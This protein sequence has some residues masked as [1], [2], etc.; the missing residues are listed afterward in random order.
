ML[1]SICN[2]N[3]ATIH[4]KEIVNG[5]V[6]HICAD[7]A[8][9]QSQDHP[10]LKGFNLA[11]MLYNFS[12]EMGLAGEVDKPGD[13]KESS[14]VMIVCPDCGWDTNK[15]RKTG[16]LGC[17]SCYA[18]FREIVSAALNNMHRGT[19]HVG[20]QPGATADKESSKMMMKLM[21]LQKELDELV[22]REEYEKA[23]VVRDKI[24]DLKKSMD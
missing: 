21:N 18:A 6:L 16:R 12:A 1:C 19:L 3:E 15:F 7:C 4:I 10:A 23:A 22:Q 9:K 24:N 17:E 20:K 5:K 11:E 14:Q 8:A 13:E 2:K